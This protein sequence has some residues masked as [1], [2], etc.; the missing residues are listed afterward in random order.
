[1]T[2]T[3]IENLQ[4]GDEVYWTDPDEGKLSRWFTLLVAPD[5]NGDIVTLV[6][7]RGD[8]LECF[9]EEIS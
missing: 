1:M 6:D 4:A 9:A 2:G 7:K 8:T 3:Q 5:I